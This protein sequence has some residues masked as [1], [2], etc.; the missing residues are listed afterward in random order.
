[1]S[2]IIR[3]VELLTA[4][5]KLR[6]WRDEDVE[7]YAAMNADSRVR[8]F[9]PSILTYAESARSAQ[10]IRAHFDRHGF[11]LW[12]VEVVGGAPFIG[13]TGLAIPSIEAPFM[14]C[15]EIGW[16]LAFEHWGHGYATEGAR[17][18]LAFG[19]T[20]LGLQ[21]I[22]AMTAPGNLRS[23]RVMDRLGMT[24]NPA[25][26]FDHPDIEPGHP[27]RRHVLY[28]LHHNEWSGAFS[29]PRSRTQVQDEG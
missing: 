2:A 18:A 10:H 6:S 29:S 22:V 26:D 25:D 19:F 7:P 15:V 13:F 11:G 1:M 4:R 17:A 16:R 23:R 8:E 5:L 24:H 14:P 20:S 9:F 28:R 27:L 3:F 21:E 12:A